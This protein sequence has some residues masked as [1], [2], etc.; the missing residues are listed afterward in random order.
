M[1]YI[2]ISMNQIIIS[3]IL[4][5]YQNKTSWIVSSFFNRIYFILIAHI[6]NILVKR[7][8]FAVSLRKKK[9]RDIINAKRRKINDFFQ[10]E[11]SK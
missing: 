2:Q 10:S 9:T 1:E 5:L 6:E 7:E 4:R 11:K 8:H 3:N